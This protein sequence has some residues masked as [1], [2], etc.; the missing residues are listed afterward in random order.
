MKTTEEFV[1]VTQMIENLI[2]REE[3][4]IESYEQTIHSIG[5]SLVKPILLSIVQEKREHRDLLKKELDELNEQFELDEA[6]I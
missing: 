1:S 3:S 5:D 4:N 2:Q 6:I